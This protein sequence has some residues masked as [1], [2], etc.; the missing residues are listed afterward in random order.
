M[1][2]YKTIQSQLSAPLREMLAFDPEQTANIDPRPAVEDPQTVSPIVKT[3]EKMPDQPS[4][5]SEQSLEVLDEANIITQF[6]NWVKD[7]FTARKQAIPEEQLAA[8]RELVEDVYNDLK[9]KIERALSN[10]KYNK[11]FRAFA[12]I[13]P[14]DQ[15][16]AAGFLEGKNR[17]MYILC[18]GFDDP[19]GYR[20]S[21]TIN[22]A[23]AYVSGKPYVNPRAEM[24]Q[25]EASK[26]NDIR[27]FKD[28]MNS[29]ESIINNSGWGRCDIDGSYSSSMVAVSIVLDSDNIKEYEQEYAIGE[30]L[31]ILMG[32]NPISE[33]CTDMME[34]LTAYQN[35]LENTINNERALQQY[36]YKTVQPVDE[37]I[38]D[39]NTG[40]P[41]LLHE[42]MRLQDEVRNKWDQV[43][44]FIQ[45]LMDRFSDAIKRILL[46]NRPYLEKYK[47]VILNTKWRADQTFEYH[48][49]Y[50]EAT[51]RCFNT[52]VPEFSYEVF[53]PALRADGYDAA[54]KQFMSGKGFR[55]DANNKNIA[56]QFKSYFLAL[57][58]GTARGRFSDINPRQLYDFCYNTN[59][60]FAVINKDREI[61]KRASNALMIAVNKEMREKGENPMEPRSATNPIPNQV[62]RTTNPA[63]NTGTNRTTGGA[64]T[65]TAVNA[66]ATVDSTGKWVLMEADQVTTNTNSNPATNAAG[67]QNRNT[68]TTGLKIGS[69][70]LQQTNANGDV[71]NPGQQ[72]NK[73]KGTTTNQDM[74]VILQ[75]WTVLCRSLIAAK[76]TAVQKIS[77]DYMDI[78]R[79]HVKANAQ[80]AQPEP[81]QQK[82]K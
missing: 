7:K 11:N 2:D 9:P 32:M 66:S 82:V 54:L 75:K 46:N 31:R 21:D 33:T 56:D 79:A 36:I 63:A 65:Q 64:T 6:V 49:N 48:G 1:L 8:R 25:D 12:I 34:Y 69:T 72:T 16:G 20:V 29:V 74:D 78:I 5:F 58:Y 67:S 15:K 61:L 55:Y 50:K 44:K 38:V 28:F 81:Q 19:N 42:E 27:A 47:D 10:Y 22:K 17:S 53:A 35:Y 80:A 68:V 60:I 62:V 4:K 24:K 77:K 40:E 45:N 71:T 76:L 3:M 23:R 14:I 73:P 18:G 52:P 51:E 43:L 39:C 13:H 30:S 41:I 57:E 70:Q 59:N 26:S 37:S